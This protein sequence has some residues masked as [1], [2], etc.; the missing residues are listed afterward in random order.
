[1]KYIDTTSNLLF[2]AL[3]DRGNL[4]MLSG[5][6]GRGAQRKNHL[7]PSCGQTV[8]QQVMIIKVV[9]AIIRQFIHLP[10]LFEGSSLNV[11]NTTTHI[12]HNRA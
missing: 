10:P 12:T 5:E 4:E 11:Y 9:G 8:E 1:M 6:G 7:A 3:V 2:A